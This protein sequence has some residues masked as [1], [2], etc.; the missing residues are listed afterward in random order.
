ML[1]IQEEDADRNAVKA[2]F[3]CLSSTTAIQIDEMFQRF[4]NWYKLK[5]FVGWILRFKNGASDAV[6]RRK[7]GTSSLPRT[8][9]KIRPLDVEELQSAERAIIEAVQTRSFREERLSLKEA[10]KVK[11]SSHIISLDPVLMEGTLRV[12]GCLQ[13]L[14][15]QNA[16]KHP[17]ILPKDHHISNLIVRHYHGISRHNNNNNNKCFI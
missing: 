17:A 6:T 13:N 7:E 10:K 12:G 9:Q 16:T 5:K 3:V 15:L 8:N 14:P 11:K 4:S 2:S 1:N